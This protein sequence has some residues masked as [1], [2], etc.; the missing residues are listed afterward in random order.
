MS[1]PRD[2]AW[3]AMVPE[4]VVTDLA[5]SLRFWCGLCGFRVA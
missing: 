2:F 5:A 4:L 3:S 1:L